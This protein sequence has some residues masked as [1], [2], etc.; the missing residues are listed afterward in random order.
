VL[1]RA[2]TRE[3]SVR[4]RVDPKLNVHDGANAIVH[5]YL[6]LQGV[7][8]LHSD[9]IGLAR[10]HNRRTLWEQSRK[11]SAYCRSRT[12]VKPGAMAFHCLL[13]DSPSAASNPSPT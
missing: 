2:R 11:D 5:A 8:E 13:C 10:E 12:V 3:K 7:R 9:E 1:D 6:D 4:E